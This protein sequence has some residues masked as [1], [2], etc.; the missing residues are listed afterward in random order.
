MRFSRSPLIVAALCLLS[1]FAS[2]AYATPPDISPTAAAQIQAIRSIKANATAPERKIS[3]RLVLALLHARNDSRVAL[4]TDFRFIQPDAD[5]RVPVD[6]AL[7]DAAAMKAVLNAIESLGGEVLAKSLAYRSIRANV[8]LDS[9]EVLAETAGLRR[10]RE[11]VPGLTSGPSTSRDAPSSIRHLGGALPKLIEAVNV[12]EGDVTH[13]ADTARGF[14]GV[15]GSGVK[16][17]VLSDGVDSIVSLQASGDLPASIDVLPGQ[18]GSGDEGSAMLEIIHDL[19]PGADLGFATA[20]PNEATFAQ[21][22]LD[23]AAAGCDIIVDDIIYLDESPFQDGPV[24]QSVNTVT[25]NGVIYFSSAGNEGNLTDGTS[26]TWEGDFAPSAAGD[27]PPLSGASLHDFGDGGNSILVETGG[28]GNTPVLLIWAESYDISSGLASTDFDVYDMDGGLTTIFDAS[29]DVQDGSGGDDF[30]IEFISG[31]AFAGERLLIDQFAAGTTSSTPMMNLIV[32]RGELDD[33][34]ATSGATRGHSATANAFS[35]AATPAAVAFGSGPPGPYPG[36]FSATDITETFSSDG[37]RR[38]ILDPTGAELTPGN[39]T[40]TGGVLRQKPDITAADGVATAAPGFNPF[41]G[42]SAAAPHA[43]AIAALVKSAVPAITPAQLRTALVSSAIDIEAAG[44]DRDTGVGIVMAEAA[45]QA[46][47]GVPAAFL[48]A[49]AAVP[50]QVAG[51]GDANIETNEDW[52]LSIPLQNSGGDDATSITAVL[53][54]TTPGVSIISANSAYPDLTPAASAPNG[55]AYLFHVDPGFACGQSIDFSLT[56]TYAGGSSPQT[57]NLS[58][59]T[60][61]AG[62]PVTTA[63]SGAAVPIPDGADLSGGNPGAP[64]DATLALSGFVANVMD[65]NL[66]IDGATCSTAVGSATVGIDHSFVNDLE[67]TLLSPDGTAVKVIDQT[68][69]SGNNLCQT[70]LDDQ[71][72]GPSIQSVVTANAPFTG[73]FTPNQPLAALRGKSIDG[74]WLLRAQ[75]FYS[76][77]TGNI[78]AWS[79]TVTPAVCDAPVQPAQLTATKSVSGSAPYVEGQAI[80]YTIVL[81]NTGTGVQPDNAG[82][83]FSDLLPAGLTAGVPTAT[84]GTIGAAGNLLSWNGSLLPGASVTLTIP[85]TINIGTSG[86]TIDNQGTVNFDADRNGTNESSAPTDD[87]NTGTANDPTSIFVGQGTLTISPTAAPFGDQGINTAS[88]PIDITLGNSGTASLDVTALTTPIAPFSRVGGTCSASLPI[89]IAAGGSCTLS[90]Q[91]APTATGPFSQNISVTA[92]APGSGNIALSGNGVQGMLSVSPNPVAFP[93]LLVG[94]SLNATLTI[95]NTGTGA[96]QVTSLDAPSA[97]FGV[98][99]GTCGPA[100]FSL[101]ASTSCTIDYSFA[102]T[103]TGS[104]SQTLILVSDVQTAAI[105]LTGSASAA[106]VEV[107]T[108]SDTGRWALM[109]LVAGIA[110]VELRRRLRRT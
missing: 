12:S 25:G 38:I 68:D 106:P 103:T 13:G 75:D 71:S 58:L 98:A 26:G 102:P 52:S 17:C 46:A 53:S 22:I 14:Y 42:T 77:D 19:A 88:A 82:D 73:S 9:L 48:G 16:V 23:L 66:S 10:I 59:N 56:V 35:T 81:T 51:D 33:A 105:D 40:S 27:P 34:L 110:V 94:S 44:T 72:A 6:I 43:A 61:S 76:Q 74:N 78:R 7:A 100:P 92:N 28:G 93:D 109:L 37:P 21:N 11:H 108:L 65:V 60:G 89:T 36:L 39:R 95:G 5:G 20:N 64:A 97:P 57:F 30:A 50:T 63:Y 70:V 99:G 84:A 85:A 32:F 41:Y 4:L 55:T 3:S 54:T 96:L 87:P 45:L 62:A 1:A 18:A 8:R 69:G 104:F 49:L 47:G 24:A 107:P 31:G 83:E 29:T 86:T 101:A 67:I 90:Y 2:A 79:L 15:D 91:F 80:T